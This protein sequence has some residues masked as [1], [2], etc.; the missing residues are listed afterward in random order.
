MQRTQRLPG[1][2]PRAARLGHMCA[3]QALGV[4]GHAR[5]GR[6]AQPPDELLP[7]SAIYLQRVLD[8]VEGRPHGYHVHDDPHLCC[9]GAL[10]LP[11]RQTPAIPDYV[12][13][14]LNQRSAGTPFLSKRVKKTSRRRQARPRMGVTVLVS[15]RC[16]RE[17]LTM[18]DETGRLAKTQEK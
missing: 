11:P 10:P 2:A 18:E 17:M 13:A 6:D 14:D 1:A 8:G 12:P 15:G 9:G 16:V 7:R 5:A 3:E 4:V